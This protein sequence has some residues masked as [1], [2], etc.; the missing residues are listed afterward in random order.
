MQI[1]TSAAY[2]NEE[3]RSEFGKIPSS[4]LPLKNERLF[5]HQ[6]EF[7]K[8]GN[9][10]IYITLPTSFKINDFERSYLELNNVEIIFLSDK[11]T[12]SESIFQALKIINNPKDEVL[13]LHGDTLFSE[14]PIEK[15][16]AYVS[17]IEDEYNWGKTNN[18][19]A[20]AGLFQ[21]QD[22]KLLSESLENN[23]NNFVD[24]INLYSQI[25]Q[26]RPI[27]VI[28]WMDFGHLNT[29]F[30]SKA[31]FTTERI[32]NNLQIDKYTVKKLSTNKNKILAE[33]EWYHKIPTKLKKYI[34]VVINVFNEPISGYELE[35]LYLNTLSELYV[36]GN[37]DIF[38]WKI[39]FNAINEYFHDTLLNSEI[40]IIPS[41]NNSFKLALI[42][43]TDQRLSLFFK[44]VK[45]NRYE[46]IK[47][48]EE[49]L[50]PIDEIIKNINKSIRERDNICY[51]HGDFCFSNIMFDFRKQMIKVIDPRGVDFENNVTILGDL[52]YDVA[53][54]SH[55]IL[56]LYDFIIANRFN[57]S[58][59]ELENK[60]DFEIKITNQT[61]KIQE[62]FINLNIQG[63]DINSKSNLAI[64]IHLFLSMLPLHYDNTIRQHALFANA[65]RLYKLY[66][67]L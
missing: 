14:F 32:F 56:G 59:K 26:I 64:I 20:Y 10:Q 49:I 39:I 9:Q 50:P 38:I 45:L 7:L 23:N 67:K 12:L 1:I 43:K 5:K 28:D 22:Q 35:Y 47:F 24:A 13:I 4:F 66:N 41:N 52:R 51:S 2:I 42:K 19:N 44:Q 16:M 63:I 18:N 25:R 48:N 3:L 8:K 46:K 11:L 62:E 40:E 31:R 21:F 29:Y 55:S 53:K 54:L 65:L 36:F 60:I 61:L 6:I 33:A 34:P 30:R 57:L 27:Q 58:V 37:N 17:T 15:D